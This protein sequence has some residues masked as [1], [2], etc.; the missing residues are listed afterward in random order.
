MIFENVPGHGYGH[1]EEYEKLSDIEYGRSGRQARDE[2][3]KSV[4][5]PLKDYLFLKL[6]F[7]SQSPQ[8]TMFQQQSMPTQPQQ[9]IQ[10]AQ[11]SP[12]GE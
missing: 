2:M 8:Q 1:V 10:P 12:S 6:G 11:K 9:P 4:I 3:I 7:G 5:S